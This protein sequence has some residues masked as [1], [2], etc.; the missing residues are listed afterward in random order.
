MRGAIAAVTG[1]PCPIRHAPY[2][3]RKR[4]PCD[5]EIRRLRREVARLCDLLREHGI[6]PGGSDRESA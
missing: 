5:D 3:A 6:E 4:V 2:R 1:D